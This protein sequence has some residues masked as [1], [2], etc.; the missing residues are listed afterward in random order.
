LKAKD[1]VKALEKRHGA[2]KLNTTGREWAFF[3]ELRAGTGYSTYDYEQKK[4]KP[5]NPEQR[6]DAWAINLYPSKKHER[7]V[8]EIKVSRSDFL[9]EI[10][11]P[12]KREQALNLSNYFYFATPKGLVSIDEIPDECGLIE[13]DDD[14]TTKVIKKAPYRNSEHLSW[15][16][17][18]SLA[19]R[20]CVAERQVKDLENRIRDEAFKRNA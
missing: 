19:R 6:F 20:A 9:H 13:L 12:D 11:N 3:A 7:I 2:D 5:F 18:C 14:L 8:Y 17:V 1:V 15:Q 16:F 4:R 10:K